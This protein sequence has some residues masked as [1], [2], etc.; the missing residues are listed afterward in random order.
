MQEASDMSSFSTDCPSTQQKTAG[1]AENQEE[2]KAPKSAFIAFCSFLINQGIVL[3]THDSD[4]FRLQQYMLYF[5]PE[6]QY[7]PSRITCSQEEII[8]YSRLI[9]S[10]NQHSFH[11]FVC[12]ADVLE[13]LSL[14]MVLG[15]LLQVQKVM[16]FRIS[17]ADVLMMAASGYTKL[18]W[19]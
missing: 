13:K 7:I 11:D 16:E 18:W 9:W 15:T 4:Y 14:A 6:W 10:S 19:K 8:T 12:I 3:Y 2:G 5:C 1:E 17:A